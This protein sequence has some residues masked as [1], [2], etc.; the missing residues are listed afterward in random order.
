[1]KK[2]IIGA[3]FFAVLSF[4]ANAQQSQEKAYIVTLAM[5]ELAY[6]AKVLQKMPY[7]EVAGLLAKLQNQVD[8]QN[9]TKDT[10]APK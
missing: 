10:A 5:P 4:P 9:K 6:I 8:E 7:E 2:T 3:L 1:M